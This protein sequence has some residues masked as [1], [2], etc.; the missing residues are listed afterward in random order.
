MTRAAAYKGC[1]SMS[2]NNTTQRRNAAQPHPASMLLV[3]PCG[4]FTD[5]GAWALGAGGVDGGA[6]GQV[7]EEGRGGQRPVARGG[8]HP[9][10]APAVVPPTQEPKSL[11]EAGVMTGR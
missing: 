11:E 4:C 3:R 9:P 8:E 10:S 6:A 7:R 5:V 1:A 2:A